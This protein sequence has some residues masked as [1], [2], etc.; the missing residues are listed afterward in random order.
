MESAIAKEIQM[1]KYNGDKYNIYARLKLSN[2]LF[3]AK[4]FK[5]IEEFNI[6]HYL[7]GES[8]FFGLKNGTSAPNF[9]A[10][11]WYLFESVETKI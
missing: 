11:F 1:R 8:I 5:T 4:K 6:G 10:I 7:I 9:F 2:K 3:F